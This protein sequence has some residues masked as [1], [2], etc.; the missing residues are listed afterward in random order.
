VGIYTKIIEPL[1][2]KARER[3]DEFVESYAQT[4]NQFTKEFANT[5]CLANGAINWEKLVRFN[6]EISN[7]NI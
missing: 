1:G 6:S 7:T 2:H 3:N 5:F 4:I